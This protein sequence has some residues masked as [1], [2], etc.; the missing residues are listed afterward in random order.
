MKKSSHH[1]IT[2]NNDSHEIYGDDTWEWVYLDK[3][4]KYYISSYDVDFSSNTGFQCLISTR[5]KFYYCVASMLGYLK[6]RSRTQNG[7]YLSRS[8]TQQQIHNS[9][10]KLLNALIRYSGLGISGL[11]SGREYMWGYEFENYYGYVDSDS[12]DLVTEFLKENNISLYEFITNKKY[13]VIIDNNHNN[14]QHLIDI[15]VV[16]KSKIV[17]DFYVKPKGRFR[18]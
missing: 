10:E 14:L 8:K 11:K 7:T 2:T 16:D 15:G 1:I 17:S 18:K 4:Y 6:H 13:V 5:H 12:K 9:Y 3:Y